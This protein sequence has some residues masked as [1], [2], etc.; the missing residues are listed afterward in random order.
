MTPSKSSLAQ[1]A[2]AALIAVW[3][4]EGICIPWE[5]ALLPS[6]FAVHQIKQLALTRSAIASFV[7]VLLVPILA[8]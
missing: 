8:A 1:Q 4:F 6:S 2:L 5:L 7:A 3:D